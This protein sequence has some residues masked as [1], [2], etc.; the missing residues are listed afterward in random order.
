MK[1]SKL[2]FVPGLIYLLFAFGNCTPNKDFI[3]PT[4]EVLTHNNWKID[5][6][7]VTKDLTPDYAGYQFLFSSTG[8][9]VLQKQN[10]IIPGS[11][12]ISATSD[13]TEVLSISFNTT[14]ANISKFNQQWAIA[15][16][17]ASIVQ[18]EKSVNQGG[19]SLLRIKNQ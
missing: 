7:F 15:G 9:V 14:D 6:F 2:L 12:K 18:F 16:K 3:A 5:Y 11:W 13:N 17:S 1:N 10:E 19:T 4:D 8:S